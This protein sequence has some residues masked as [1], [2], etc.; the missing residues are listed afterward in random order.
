MP[1]RKQISFVVDERGC[2]ICT[3]HKGKVGKNRLDY[4]K[5]HRDGR[6]QQVDRY[7]WEISFG[8]RL[9]SKDFLCHTCDNP[10]CI[11]IKHLFVGTQKDNMQDAMKKGRANRWDT[12]GMAKLSPEKVKEIRASTERN[13]VLAKKYGVCQATIC[14]VKKHKNWRGV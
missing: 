14:L 4:P 13:Y 1:Q 7:L 3:S 11:N 9:A 8:V 6:E 10:R 5:L 12:N 2:H